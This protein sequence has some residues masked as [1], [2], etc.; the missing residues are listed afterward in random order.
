MIGTYLQI[1][2]ITLNCYLAQ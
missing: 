2:S 1:Q